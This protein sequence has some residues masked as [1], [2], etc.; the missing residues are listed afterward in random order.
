V[1]VAGFLGDLRGREIQLWADGDRLRCKAPAGVLTPEL[2]GEL[3]RRKAEILDFLRSAEA[4]ARQQ[5]AIVPLQPHGTRL[6]VFAV[7]GH[8]GDVFTYRTLAEQLGADQPFFGLQPPG[9]D[10]ASAPLE[11]AEDLAAYFAAQI[12]SFWPAGPCIIAGFC[13]GG[14]IAF[15]LSRQLQ[16]GGAEVSLLAMFACP[17]PNAFRVPQQWMRTVATHTQRIAARR[18]MRARIEY[19]AEV[20]ANR[21]AAREEQAR[22]AADVVLARRAAVEQ[23]TLAGVRRYKPVRFDGRAALFLPN[24]AWTR[25]G[26]QPLRWRSLVAETEEFYGPDRVTMDVMLRGPDTP[27]IA[28]FFRRLPERD[29][30]QAVR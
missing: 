10:G 3:Q 19:V 21:Q 12:R 11:R 9:L 29:A 22:A 8:N 2:Q 30:V 28:D 25:S 6:P 26:F 15:E 17:Y 23:A 18:S 16:Q 7:A 27:M 5:P 14:T 4:V 13:A 20:R 1:S 24:Q